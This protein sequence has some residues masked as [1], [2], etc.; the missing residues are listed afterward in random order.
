MEI[1]MTWSEEAEKAVSRVPFFVRKRV[2]GEVEKE[3]ARQGSKRVLIEH[4][5][6][7]RERFLAGKDIRIKGFQIE[8]CFGSGGCENRAVESSQLVE[9]LEELLSKRDFAVFLKKKVGGNLKF[10][11]EF[12]VSISDCPNSCSR[13]QIVDIGIIGALRPGRTEISDQPCAGCGACVAACREGA[14]DLTQNE[15]APA[16]DPQKCVQCGKC[17]SA[18]PSGALTEAAKGWRILLGG[19]LG[20]R[21]QL[22]REL[23]GIYSSEEVLA[24]VERCLDLYFTHNIAGERLGTILNRIGYSTVSTE[25]LQ[26]R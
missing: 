23:T 19:K 1:C 5:S 21:P 10:H 22:G 16:L 3:A 4:V 14:V 25:D 2:R 13:P 18:C 17:V 26:K 7:C 20:R 9:E 6:A 12:R 8:T 15:Q 24:I 11:H